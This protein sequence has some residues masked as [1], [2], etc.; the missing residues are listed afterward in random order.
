[1][2][3]GSREAGAQLLVRREVALAGEVH[4]ALPAATD[5]VR[6]D[7]RDH[8]ALAREEVGRDRLALAEVV[9]RL[10]R[11]PA[12]EQDAVGIVEDDDRLTA[13]LDER[14]TPDCVRVRHVTRF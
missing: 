11:P 4:K 13:L 10:S 7:Q 12:R 6:N 1:V 9:D 2:G 14:P 5:L 8:A 3:D